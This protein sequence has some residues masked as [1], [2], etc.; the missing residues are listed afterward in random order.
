MDNT[1]NAFLR[2]VIEATT[3][4]LPV[5]STGH[6]F[7]FS[8]FFPFH[9]L[10]VNA[11]DFDDL[12]DI[13]IQT[14]AIFS[15]VVLY[16]KLF[17]DRTRDAF[18]YFKTKKNGL[19][20]FL[21][22]RNIFIGI[23][24]ILILGFLFKS[25]LNTIK[26]SEH[27]LLIL[28]LSWLIGGIIMILVEYKQTKNE[29]DHKTLG[30]REAMIIGIFQ[31]FALIPGVSR[32]AAT[33]ITARILGVSKKDSAEFS[34]FLAIPVLTLAGLY[35][36]Y[37]HRAI[38]NSETIGLLLFGSIISFIICYF[39]IKLFMAFLKRRS[40]VSFGV[41]RLFLGVFVILYFYRY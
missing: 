11:S 38:L 10:S 31:C 4:F 33:I 36:L 24:P 25:V 22:Y 15:V 21:F 12:F 23:L 37:K 16:F 40:F 13:F 7:L 32:S 14:G 34:F 6:L 3:E 30:I 39:I 1:V 8:Y 9:D 35:K 41:Y 19:E 26:E 27:L 29:S 18:S 17:V 5:S 20:G 2:G 28:G